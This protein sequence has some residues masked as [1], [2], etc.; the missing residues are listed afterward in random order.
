M[1]AI[2]GPVNWRLTIPELTKDIIIS[3]EP[4]N[5]MWNKK[6]NTGDKKRARMLWTIFALEVWYKKCYLPYA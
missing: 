4:V 5:T 6:I 1:C 2:K 3:P